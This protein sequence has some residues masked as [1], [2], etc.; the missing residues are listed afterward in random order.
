[1]SNSWANGLSVC[2]NTFLSNVVCVAGDY[3]TIY[4]FKRGVLSQQMRE[5]DLELDRLRGDKQSL[6][7]K[8]SKLQVQQDKIDITELQEGYVNTYSNA[9]LYATS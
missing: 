1:M 3:I 8:L 2:C 4:Q 9:L 5:K 6:V 7:E